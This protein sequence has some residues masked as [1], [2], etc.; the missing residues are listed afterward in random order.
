MDQVEYG[1]G[2]LVHHVCLAQ[3]LTNHR[4][5]ISKKELS[6][7]QNVWHTTLSKFSCEDRGTFLIVSALCEMPRHFARVLTLA[8]LFHHLYFSTMCTCLVTSGQ[9]RCCV[10]SL[11]GVKARHSKLSDMIFQSAMLPTAHLY[12]V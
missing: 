5:L 12:A 2:H 8:V 10:T 6:K 11:S 1:K 4:A 9:G 3:F 7:L